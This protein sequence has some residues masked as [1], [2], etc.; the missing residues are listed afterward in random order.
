MDLPTATSSIAMALAGKTSSVD[1]PKPRSIGHDK[2]GH[3]K[4]RHGYHCDQPALLPTPPNSISPT[5]PPQ[6]YKHKY[7]VFPA[8][9]PTAP[10]QIESDLDLQDPVENTSHPK[11]DSVGAGLDSAG[12]ITPALLAKH[13]LPGILLTHGPLAI[14]HVMGYLTTSVPGFARI[15]PAK[16]RRL[17]VASLEGRGTDNGTDVIF[18][19]VGWGRWDA[20]RRGQP[21]RDRTAFN[22]SPPSRPSHL[23]HPQAVQIPRGAPWHNTDE[24]VVYG[25]S[26][27]GDSA[28][29]SHSDM[30]Y[31]DHEDV[32]MLEHEAD[33]MSLDEDYCSSSEPPDDAAVPDDEWDEGDITDEEDWAKIGADALR[34]RSL[35][36]GGLLPRS[37]FAWRTSQQSVSRSGGGPANSILA[38]SSPRQQ[39]KFHLPDDIAGDVEERAAIEAL[40]QLGSM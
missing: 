35:N 9:P 1:I 15:P 37:S 6:A 18:E 36:G 22:H 4:T 3:T 19:K 25:S 40:L 31:G 29:F 17:V 7:A 38:K 21:A 12:A 27:T 26:M 32:T 2:P 28:V 20:R 5:L 33:K 11:H 24:G 16:A 39:F 13:H 30:D 23:D 10:F 8:S 14:R 34:A